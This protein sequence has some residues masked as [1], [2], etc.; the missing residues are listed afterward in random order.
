[1]SCH[2]HTTGT[3]LWIQY[4]REG[5]EGNQTARVTG[6]KFEASQ[7]NLDQA[8]A[9]YGMGGLTLP[10]GLVNLW[11]RCMGVALTVEQAQGL[12]EWAGEV[13]S[14][15]LDIEPS[16]EPDIQWAR[17]PTPHVEAQP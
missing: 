16:S 10:E 15:D 1:M 2:E 9:D 6:V 13:L 14:L 8:V 4:V 3:G 11:L 7:A 12:L 17:K 5:P